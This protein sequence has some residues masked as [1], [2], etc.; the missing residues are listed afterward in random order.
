[1]TNSEVSTRE[2][3]ILYLVIDNYIKTGEPVGSSCLVSKYRLPWS[4]ATVRSVMF[5][6]MDKNYLVQPH[7]SAG[8]V[9]TEKG[10]RIYINSLLDQK[11]LPKSKRTVI[12]RR[13][14][15]LDGTLNEVIY[16]TSIM[17]SDISNCTGLA[18]LPSTRSM[19]IKS[20]KLI[21]IADRKVLVIIVFDNGMID[22]R[23][24]RLSGKIPDGMLRK[25]SDYVN[26][27]TMAL[28]LDEVES[29]VID[30]L[31]H[32]R[33]I[34]RE[35]LERVVKF[36]TGK[37]DERLKSAVYIKGHPSIFDN[38]SLNNPEGLKDL[39]RALEEK[40]FLV[41]ILGKAMNEDSTIVFLGAE[42]GVPAGYSVIAA[43]YGTNKNLGTLG[44][45]GPLHM[46]YGQ[47]VPLVDYT[48][49]IVSN[50]VGTGG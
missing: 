5:E 38:Y 16:E 33:R 47:I 15:Q 7:I 48:A 21:R 14:K 29:I 20:T 50:I 2:K 18:T 32:E 45:L 31:K 42:N 6:L 4:P 43:P 8:R 39:F 26:K 24:I 46:D 34:Y 25:L 49:K 11:K 1:M 13:Y 35:F 40:S 19:K 36:S 23:M 44:V 10:I 37:F 27:L 17:L 22:Q 9:P 41:E 12:K 30:K 3:R 28:T